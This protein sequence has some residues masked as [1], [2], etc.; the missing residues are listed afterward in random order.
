MPYVSTAE[1]QI[2]EQHARQITEQ[3]ELIRK[4]LSEETDATKKSQLEQQ[5]KVLEA[6]RQPEPKI[7]A[8]W[9]RGEP[10]PTY[11]LKRGNY[12]TPGRPVEP[13]IPSVLSN[14]E[15]PFEVR[16]PWEHAKPTGRR[17]AWRSLAG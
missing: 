1:R 7:G 15:M 11:I 8:L 14:K 17:L 9:S 3:Q 2:Y 13:R 4:Q 6:Q 5:I 12:R 10:S 16:P